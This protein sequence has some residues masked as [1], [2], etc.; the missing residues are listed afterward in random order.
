[1]YIYSLN[2]SNISKMYTKC[3][4]VVNNNKYLSHVVDTIIFGIS[5]PDYPCIAVETTF[6]GQF[7][8]TFQMSVP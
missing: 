4:L 2:S 7:Q 1:M 3:V 5:I 8:L 6:L